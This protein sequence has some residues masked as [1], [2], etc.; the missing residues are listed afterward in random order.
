MPQA[1]K[2]VAT[3]AYVENLLVERQCMV[4]PSER[5][6]RNVIIGEIIR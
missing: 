3:A 2:G 6:S 4:G 1:I 5:E